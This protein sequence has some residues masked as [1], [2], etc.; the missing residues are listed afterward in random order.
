MRISDWS[1]DVCSSDLATRDRTLR[2]GG[3][4]HRSAH[5][6]GIFGPRYPHHAKLCGHP[7]EHLADALAD[8]VKYAPAAR[9]GIVIGVDQHVLARQMTGQRIAVRARF[10]GRADDHRDRKSTRLKSSP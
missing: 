2:R 4:G 7:V 8:A 10:G 5:P 9:T 1:S 6:A 3:L